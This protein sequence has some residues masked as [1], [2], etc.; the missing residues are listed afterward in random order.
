VPL[1]LLLGGLEIAKVYL[2]P[3]LIRALTEALK[4]RLDDT[5]F[6]K[7]FSW[8]IR[9]DSTALRLY[10]LRYSEECDVRKGEV[11]VGDR[12]RAL[13]RIT[14]QSAKV[15][16]GT[17]GYVRWDMGNDAD[18]GEED[19]DEDRD[20]EV[21]WDNGYF[22]AV[23]TVRDQIEVVDSARVNP[24]R[25]KFVANQLSPE[26]MTELAALWGRPQPSTKKR[27]RML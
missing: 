8:A 27:R 10:C 6:D 14:A 3:H 9:L 2:I 21:A 20:I 15:P 24:V 16:K 23:E 11:R 19:E 25:K 4:S 13:K 5:T 22:N 12:V 1:H 7:I 17:Y 26:V 18:E